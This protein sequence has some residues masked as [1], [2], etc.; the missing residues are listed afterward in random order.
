LKIRPSAPDGPAAT[1]IGPSDR[2]GVPSLADRW[3]HR[4]V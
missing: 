2:T 1:T 3:R 4:G